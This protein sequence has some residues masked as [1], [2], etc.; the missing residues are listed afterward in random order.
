MKQKYCYACWIA[1][2]LACVL[3]VGIAIGSV[4]DWKDR[5]RQEA[6]RSPV[7]D[8]GAAGTAYIKQRFVDPKPE[9]P[10]VVAAGSKAFVCIDDAKWLRA[11]PSV[12]KWW[13]LEITDDPKTPQ[14][15]LDFDDASTT[16]AL[17]HD[18]VLGPLPAK[19]REWMV[20]ALPP[21]R[22][23]QTGVVSSFCPH[24]DR[25]NPILTPFPRLEFVVKA[26]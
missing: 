16:R 2:A 19:C 15:R 11:C 21:G 24:V 26:P 18:G 1:F 23:V 6:D 10:A 9:Q 20:P 4:H 17:H 14:K 3:V 13:M 25:R 8:Y 7:I 5:L 12:L 22:Y